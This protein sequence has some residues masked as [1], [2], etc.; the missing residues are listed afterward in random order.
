VACSCMRIG[1]F[2]THLHFNGITRLVCKYAAM[3]Q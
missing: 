3:L 2:V 1:L